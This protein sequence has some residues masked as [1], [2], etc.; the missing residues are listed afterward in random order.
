MPGSFQLPPWSEGKEML[1]GGR[2]GQEVISLL[3]ENLLLLCLLR[4]QNQ[5]ALKM[6]RF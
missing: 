6:T 3:I 1:R 4:I 5:L 2:I